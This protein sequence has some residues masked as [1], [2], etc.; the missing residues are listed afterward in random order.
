MLK[1]NLLKTQPRD[2]ESMTLILTREVKAD[3]AEEAEEEKHQE[4]REK[5]DEKFDK[6]KRREAAAGGRRKTRGSRV[7]RDKIRTT[8]IVE[9]K[10]DKAV[11]ETKRVEDEEF[12]KREKIKS[13]A[14]KR[15][16][17][18]K[19]LEK[20]KDKKGDVFDWHRSVMIAWL[21][22]RKRPVSGTKRALKKRVLYYMNREK[23]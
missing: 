8:T 17:I 19:K 6:K 16:G 7:T 22:S 3:I 18:E 20:P 23:V 11:I 15:A 1:D 5:D 10:Q 9:R 14:H 21:K 12:K 2:E 13:V 4:K